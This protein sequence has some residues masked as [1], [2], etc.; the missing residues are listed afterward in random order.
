MK[1]VLYTSNLNEPEY[2]PSIVCDIV[3]YARKE[4]IKH[5]ITGVL[6]FDGQTFTQYVEGH[7]DDVDR[8]FENIMFDERHKN[9][10]VITVGTTTKRLYHKW[11]LG[12][13]DLTI[14]SDDSK[15][16]ISKDDLNP[17]AFHRLIDR[18]VIV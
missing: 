16:I 10:F 1:F 14:Q 3:R 13:I 9:V 7:D 17:E 4:N 12:F 11:E 15:N 8:L 5:S 2:D 6:I 18:F